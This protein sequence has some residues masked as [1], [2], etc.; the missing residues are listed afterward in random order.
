[1]SKRSWSLLV[2]LLV[3]LAA[4]ACG[5]LPQR[6]A[7]GCVGPPRPHAAARAGAGIPAFTHPTRYPIAHASGD[8]YSP[9]GRAVALGDLNRDGAPDLAA[10]HPA[11]HSSVVSVLLNRGDGSFDARHDYGTGKGA[12]AV[13]L[14]DLDC[15]GTRDLVI[16]NGGT[17]SV[18]ILLNRGNGRFEPQHAY[19]ASS[20]PWAVAVADLDGDKYPDLAVA[21]LNGKPEQDGS[22][23]SVSVLLNEGDGTFG[24]PTNYPTDGGYPEDLSALDI[25]GDGRLDL[26]VANSEGELV[27]LL[28]NRGEGRFEPGRHYDSG[29]GTA[30]LAAGDLDGDGKGDLVLVWTDQSDE[31]EEEGVTL[32]PSYVKT[33]L[34][35]G[36]GSFARSRLAYKDGGYSEGANAPTVVDLDGDGHPDVV[37]PRWDQDSVI[38]SL[39]QN[40]GSGRFRDEARVDYLLGGGQSADYAIAVGDLNGDGVADLVNGNFESSTLSVF[41]GQRGRCT[42]QDV[43]GATLHVYELTVAAATRALARGGCRVG[44]ITSRKPKYGATTKGRVFSQQPKFGTV[45]PAGSKVDLVVAS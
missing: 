18:S 25:D 27:Y 19:R 17:N 20:M 14:A 30:A 44:T 26:A 16:A 3:M 43:S 23:G 12:N 8:G 32:E 33:L 5:S 15:D 9:V 45:L 41:L 2:A 21:N 40:D 35:H 38:V 6:P 36:D 42:V 39:F 29:T 34:S 31:L 4:S 1:M 28:R 24:E 11:D 10:V 22:F 13:T 7:A 37:V